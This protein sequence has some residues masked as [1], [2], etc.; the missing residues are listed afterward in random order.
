MRSQSPRA[1]TAGAATLGVAFAL[2]QLALAE[3][4]TSSDGPAACVEL[5]TATIVFEGDVLDVKTGRWLGAFSFSGNDHHFR[6]DQRVIVYATER[7]GAWSTECNR[8][9][10]FEA[11]EAMALCAEL[12]QLKRCGSHTK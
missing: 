9:K 12:A 11:R 1:L 3:C 7:G 6:P 10:T 5:A 8:T 4:V 2:Q